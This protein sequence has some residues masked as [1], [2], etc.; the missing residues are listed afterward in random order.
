MVIK[1]MGSLSGHFQTK[2]TYKPQYPYPP[3]E[4]TPQIRSVVRTLRKPELTRSR[5]DE[6]GYRKPTSYSTSIGPLAVLAHCDGVQVGSATTTVATGSHVLTAMDDPLALGKHFS[7]NDTQHL[8]TKI[9]NNIRDEVLDVAM[10]LAEMQG[11]VDTI[12]TGL[13]RVGR[14]IDQFRKRKPQSFSYLMHGRRRDNRRPTDAFL[15]ETAGSYLEWKYGIM[16]TVYDIQGA[17]KGMDINTEGS[18]FSNPPLL[19][20]RAQVVRE[21]EQLSLPFT[22]G[23]SWPYMVPCT[24]TKEYKARCD[25]SVSAEGVRGLSRYGIGLST[26]AT[27][28]FDKTP[29]SFVLNMAMPIADILKAWSAL[30]GCDVVG[31]SETKFVKIVTQGAN[32]PGHGTN[33]WVRYDIGGGG[34]GMN[35]VRN[36]FSLPP[37]PV[38]FVKNPISTG[39][40]ATVLSLFTSLRK[41]K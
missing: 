7:F 36:A 10:V 21:T 2:M 12:T 3:V 15:R 31:Y 40:L 32:L 25:Y 39:N 33:A 28:A 6:S 24:V 4:S 37:M 1:P 11:T 41:A 22:T 34:E 23:W 5:P 18:L 20:A 38:P 27:V 35:F 19:V 14:S 30:A 8:R 16:P 9:L 13:H 29:F 26:V 17:C